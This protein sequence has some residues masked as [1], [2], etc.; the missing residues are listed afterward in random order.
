LLPTSSAPT[1]AGSARCTTPHLRLSTG[2][3]GG[4]AGTTYQQLRLV[5][6]GTESCTMFGFPGTSFL[7][8]SGNQVGLAAARDQAA[9]GHRVVVRPGAAA[10]FTLAIPDAGIFD[11]STCVPAKAVA[12]RVYPPDEQSAL[13]VGYR[14]TV[15][16]TKS[17]QARVSSVT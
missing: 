7:D 15:C 16:T 3:A 13:R 10:R 5:N 9:A 12:I 1:D 6:I 2:T 8:G 11:P 17:G 14:A 4:A